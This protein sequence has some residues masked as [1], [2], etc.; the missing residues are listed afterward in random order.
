MLGILRVRPPAVEKGPVRCHR[1]GGGLDWL[2]YYN[3][4]IF[5]QVQVQQSMH[6]EWGVCV[7]TSI[8][9]TCI[10]YVEIYG[11][12]SVTLPGFHIP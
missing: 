10:S 11:K 8:I 4:G 7:L 12:S 5:I 1:V 6:A 3:L 2:L 9:N